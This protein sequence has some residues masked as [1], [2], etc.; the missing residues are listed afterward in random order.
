M[1]ILF[2]GSDFNPISIACADALACSRSHEITI[3]IESKISRGRGATLVH[4]IRSYGVPFTARR[5]RDY[6]LA[7]IRIM[8]SAAA[9][10][11]GMPR[12]LREVALARRVPWIAVDRLSD[13]ATMARLTELAPDLVVVAAFSQILR[14]PMLELPVRG[15]VNVH[16]SLLPKYRGPNPF[17]WV[18]QRGERETG[19][20]VHYMDEGV[21]TGDTILQETL[22]IASS[23]G[24]RSL[25]RRSAAL[26]ASLLVR[27]VDLIADGRAPRNRQEEGSAS[28]F[29]NPPRG[30]SQL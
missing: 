10:I 25:Q 2:L 8:S 13:A 30:A 6:G 28:Y 3:G 4:A 27:A 7:R 11:G 21:D 12:S 1:R 26:G 17:Y 23:E 29:P 22:S 16:P 18:L 24:E 5:A 19:V 20:T 14:R 9:W 15:V